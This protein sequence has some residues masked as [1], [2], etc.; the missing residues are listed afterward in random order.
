M[1]ALRRC[2]VGLTL[3]VLIGACS[4]GGSK[5]DAS[6]TSLPAATT[7]DGSTI[8]PA[9]T[10]TTELGATTTTTIA[11][12]A[13]L[14]GFLLKTVP[15]GYAKLPDR[16]SDSGPTNLAKAIRDEASQGGAAQLRQ[17]GFVSG[18]QRV[19]AIGDGATQNVIFLY[20]FATPAGAA[21]YALNRAKELNAAP[22]NGP[23]VRFA[24]PMP[25]SIGLHSESPTLSFSAVVFSKGLYSVQAVS[26]DA[27]KIDQSLAAVALGQAQYDRL[28]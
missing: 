9:D 15:S 22:S 5:K 1:R 24:P 16:L 10:T 11:G 19:W 21:A 4:S 3:I 13:A 6:T 2:S 25:G 8:A 27:A 23:I 26:S 20:R 12:D 7:P 18:Y 28:P 17:S 14:A